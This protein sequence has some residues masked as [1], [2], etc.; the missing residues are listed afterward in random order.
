MADAGAKIRIRGGHRGS[1]TETLQEVEDILA[2]DS[3]D[4]TRLAAMKMSLQEKLTRMD[5]L[6]AEILGLL[7]SEDGITKDIEQSDIFKRDI[8]AALVRIDRLPTRSLDSVPSSASPVVARAPSTAS[9]IKLPK[10]TI[11]PF[12]GDP[13]S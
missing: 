13:T 6:N 7:E 1:V 10:L 4:T 3:P 5:A 8:V 2:T 11:T 12:N 9:K